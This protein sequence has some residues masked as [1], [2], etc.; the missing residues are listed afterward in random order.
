MEDLT[1]RV[2]WQLVKKEGYIAIWQKPFNN[3]C[4]MS[5]NSEVQPQLCD[6]DDQ[7]NKVWYVSLKACITRLPENGYGANVSSWPAR[8]HEPPQRLQEVDMDAYIA[9]ND[10]FEA[11]SQYWNEIVEGH[12]RVFHWEQWKLRNVMDMR[13]GFGG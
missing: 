2:C 13:A 8:S 11:E 6:S 10:I 1:S 12:V 9:R 5:R 3:L 7:P 4:Y